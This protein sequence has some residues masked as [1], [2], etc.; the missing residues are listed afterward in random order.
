[1]NQKIE[2]VLK[3]IISIL[4]VVCI[5]GFA[6]S[7][8]PKTLQNDTFYTIKIGELIEKNT[9][10]VS[11]LLPW[12][13]G[14][15]MEDHFSYHNLPY[16]Y[17][18]WLYDFLTY[19]IYSVWNFDGV[20]V[21]TCILAVIMALLIYFVNRKLNNGKIVSLFVTIGTLYCLRNFIAARAQLATFIL[22][23]LTIFGIEQFLKTK[24]LRYAFLLVIIPILIANLHCAVW[25][26]Y[27]VLYLPYIAEYICVGLA[28]ANYETF[29]KKIKLHF[30]KKKI[31]KMQYNI[32]KNKVRKLDEK[33]NKKVVENLN[34]TNKLEVN[35]EKNVK[36]LILIFVICIFTGLLTPIKDTPYTYLIKTSIGNTTQNISEHLPLTLVKNSDM[37]VV[38]AAVFGILIFSKVKIRVRDF[39]MLMGLIVLSFYS[40]RQVSMLVLIGNFIFARLICGIIENIKMKLK[41]YENGD[42]KLAAKFSSI[43]VPYVFIFCIITIS[44][45]NFLDKKKDV[46]INKNLYPVEAANYINEEII[47]KVGK[48][49]LR[50]YNEYNYGSY[51]LFSGI[52]VFIDSRADLYAP[53]F[54]GIRTKSGKYYGKDVFSDFIDISNLS[55]DYEQK[56]EQYKITHVM[57][58]WNSK[59]ST[60]I[61]KDSNYKLI[62]NDG[63]FKIFEKENV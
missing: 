1:M 35:K 61:A 20:Y 26:F 52:P 25:P 28:T 16:T 9:E 41:K 14:L 50:L 45:C 6:F 46:Y 5:A 21:A 43:L 42:L 60:L 27:F 29:A 4:C 13:K 56:F 47:P 55:T 39:F 2:K 49:N 44:F 36:W 62:Y 3:I 8:T 30:K 53:E 59:L 54:N 18:H 40:Q 37:I 33:H 24:K 58:L 22:F 10:K 34:K 11:D 32:E 63:F 57:T 19:K 38:F 23:I 17:P 48:E 51:L 12:N 15:D 31:G 7:L